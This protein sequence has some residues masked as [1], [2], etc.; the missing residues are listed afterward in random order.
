MFD[1][2]GSITD[3]FGLTDTGAQERGLD[4]LNSG[5]SNA[6]ANLDANISPVMATSSPIRA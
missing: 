2:I 4:A 1:W 5:M 3:A 6:T